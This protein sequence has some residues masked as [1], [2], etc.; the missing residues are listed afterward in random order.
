MLLL[1]LLLLSFHVSLT[2]IR[3]PILSFSFSDYSKQ[4]RKELA[5]RPPQREAVGAP[6]RRKRSAAAGKGKGKRVHRSGGGDES[7]DAASDA[8]AHSDGA[9]DGSEIDSDE[10]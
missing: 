2:H 1:L 4:R 10:V 8:D 3:N 7:A 6:S 9:A 5:R